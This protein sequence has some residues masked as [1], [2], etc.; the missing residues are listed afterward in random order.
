MSGYGDHGQSPW[1]LL[2]VLPLILCP[3]DPGLPPWGLGCETTR[4]SSGWGLGASPSAARGP[5]SISDGSLYLLCSH[6]QH[7]LPGSMSSH[8]AVASLVSPPAV[9]LSHL[10]VRSPHLIQKGLPYTRPLPRLKAFVASCRSQ[11]RLQTHYLGVRG[12]RG[13]DA[14]PPAQFYLSPNFPFPN[15]RPI[16]MALSHSRRCRELVFS[17]T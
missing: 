13:S 3:K 11:D 10:P 2:L 14:C 9:S 7:R 15:P 17:Q 12:S 1:A 8:L 5:F 4:Q 6:R 16:S